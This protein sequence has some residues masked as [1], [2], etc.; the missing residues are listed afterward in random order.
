[1]S[2]E[3]GLSD[4][5][6]K[7]YIA[8][9]TDGSSF[10]SKDKKYYEASSAIVIVINNIEVCRFGCFHKNGTNSIGEVYAMML[11]IDKVEELKRDNPEL[12]DY[13]TF[14][15]SD[16]K[17]V[18]SSLTEWIFNWVKL[19]KGRKEW[20]SSSNKPIAYQWIMKYL[21]DNY[22]SNENWVA[23]NMIIHINGHVS[24]KAIGPS[25]RKCIKRNAKKTWNYKK[26]ITMATFKELVRYNHL[27]DSVAETVRENKSVYFEERNEDSPWV[28]RKRILPV[29]NQR[30]VIKSRNNESRI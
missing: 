6:T 22:I 9:F 12:R 3:Y 27:V 19:N 16:S 1:M 30:F 18:V 15:V 14:Y 5:F 26:C 29:R 20:I 17:Y 28:K 10:I 25:Y 24:D 7:N 11:A 8:V 2:N 13:F 4:L 21:Y 23:N